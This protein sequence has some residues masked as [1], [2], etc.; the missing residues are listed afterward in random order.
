MKKTILITICLAIAI[1]GGCQNTFIGTAYSPGGKGEALPDGYGALRVSFARG[2]A[3]TAM[4]DAALKDFDL[5]FLF[6]DSAN[7]DV[8]AQQGENNTFILPEGVYTLVVKAWNKAAPARSKLVAEGS[9]SG[10]TITAGK[11]NENETVIALHP[12]VSEGG[13][14]TLTFKIIH[15]NMGHADFDL[16]AFTLNPV[17]GD[18]PPID[19]IRLPEFPDNEKININQPYT[20]KVPA[21]Y[22]LLSMTLVKTEEALI[23]GQ[24]SILSTLASQS[25]VLHIY[26]NLVT[27]KNYN[28][29][30]I[31][32]IEN[33][34]TNTHDYYVQGDKEVPGSL[35]YAIGIA[36]QLTAKTTIRVM[37]PQGSEIKLKDDLVFSARS[38][39]FIEGNGIILSKSAEPW[40]NMDYK[41]LMTVERNGSF[42]PQP[43]VT[44][45]RFHFRD[46]DFGAVDNKGNLSLESCIFSNNATTGSGGAI[47]NTDGTLEVKGCTFYN[48][49]ADISGGAIY[50]Y[51]S[52][53][54]EL[55]GNLFFGNTAPEWPLIFIY[56]SGNIDSK[57]YN[58]VD[59]ENNDY[60]DIF[61]FDD[62]RDIRINSTDLPFSPK[63]FRLFS[64]SG[65]PFASLPDDYPKKDFYGETIKAPIFAGAV[66]KEPII[67][68]YYLD[69]DKGHGNV[70]VWSDPA[71]PDFIYESETPV[72]LTAKPL[73][74]SVFEGWLVDTTVR[75]DNPLTLTMNSDTKVKARFSLLPVTSLRDESGS[76]SN[77]TFRYALSIARDDDVIK[78]KDGLVIPGVSVIKLA[79]P[80]PAITK[81][82]TIEGGGITLTPADSWKRNNESNLL[83]INGGTVKISSMHFKDGRTER[84]GAISNDGSLTLESCIFN[85][86]IADNSGAIYN[87]GNLYLKGCTFY[88]NEA[89]NFWGGAIYNEN[90][91]VELTGN[92]FY[93]NRALTAYGPII[94]PYSQK[95]KIKSKGY[96][97]VDYPFADD[98]PP[99]VWDNCGWDKVSGDIL[100]EDISFSPKTFRLFPDSTVVGC[101]TTRPADYPEQDFYGE[102][103][104][105]AAGAVQGKTGPGYYLDLEYDSERGGFIFS[106]NEPDKDGLIYGTTTLTAEAKSGYSFRY[107][108]WGVDGHSVAITLPL[109]GIDS[110]YLSVRAVFEQFVSDPGDGPDSENTRGTLRYALTN[111]KDGETIRF[112]DDISGREIG[113]YKP[114]KINNKTRFTRKSSRSPETGICGSDLPWIMS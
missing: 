70:T 40:G 108:E 105:S 19:V 59:V 3:R 25:E 107:W 110:S 17:F 14:G 90:G 26:Q 8:T 4:P 60:N 33:I 106:P 102:P 53:T 100:L 47:Q 39:L 2:T 46:S 44:I 95:Q 38:D 98:A 54:I 55:T 35:R 113:L 75:H 86:N 57:G 29:T 28:F 21:G 36:S 7:H 71:S 94:G 63:T 69:L 114:L 99:T 34:V 81:S 5:E 92:L 27:E 67:R 89:L 9:A 62:G 74:G 93:G 87:Q 96:N 65:A 32:F 77:I 73:A 12:I 61:Y 16:G 50:N 24:T 43:K 76:L 13:S 49:H 58:A 79:R 22:Y 85:G 15:T 101:I 1:L 111:A 88:K 11:T 80:L 83:R 10:I 51:G 97:V 82:I 56:G 66:Q 23:N 37:L 109:T 42:T 91:N 104:G 64:D 41:R 31:S 6:K 84:G 112:S 68:G 78:F 72:T 18:E 45:S 48:N 20:V 103:M 52:E 30:D